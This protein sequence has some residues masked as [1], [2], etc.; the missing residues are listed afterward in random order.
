[1]FVSNVAFTL[2]FFT[3]YTSSFQYILNIFASLKR[4]TDECERGFSLKVFFKTVNLCSALVPVR[5]VRPLDVN[6]ILRDKA[7]G[8]P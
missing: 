5:F 8:G 1:M 2:V 3:Q 6:Y 7:R 4:N